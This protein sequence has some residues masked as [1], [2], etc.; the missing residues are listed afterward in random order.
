MKDLEIFINQ[1]MGKNQASCIAS[2]LKGEEKK[3]FSELLGRWSAIVATMPATYETV[4]DPIAYLNYF[5]GGFDCWI[6]EKDI[7]EDQVQAFGLVKFSWGHAEMGCVSI[8]EILQSGAELDL[9]FEQETI[10]EIKGR[11]A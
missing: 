5:A 1:F 10:D 11:I 7:E 6:S 8:P 2:M 9:Y 4:E 3:H